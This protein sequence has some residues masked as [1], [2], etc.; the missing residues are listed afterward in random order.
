L[1]VA[2]SLDPNNYIYTVNVAK[3]YSDSGQKDLAIQKYEQ[4]LNLNGNDYLNWNSLGN[5]YFETGNME[6]AMNAYNKAILLNPAEKVF[7]G[8]KALIYIQEGRWTD[9]E[10]LVNTELDDN[11]KTF[12][13]E[14]VARLYP[15]LQINNDAGN[16]IKIMGV[17]NN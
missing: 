15:E 2:L 13:L 3:A 10:Q 7:V 1:N 12:F 11:T 8:N 17:I 9:A 4:A 6:Q 14:T 16:G 5:L